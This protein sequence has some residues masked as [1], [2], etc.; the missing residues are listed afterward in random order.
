MGYTEQEAKNFIQYIAPMIRA[1]ATKRGYAICST[2][3]AQ[4]I[5]EGAAGTSLLAKAFFNHFGMK[6][7]NTWKGKTVRL[8][9][10]EEYKRGILTDVYAVFRAYDS[11]EEGVKGYYD[12]ISIKRYANLKNAKDYR[13]Y[14]E[15][16]KKDGWA[17]SSSYVENLIS[18]VEKYSLQKYDNIEAVIPTYTKGKTYKTNVNLNIRVAPEGDRKLFEDITENAK[19]HSFANEDGFAVLKKDSKVTCRDIIKDGDNLWMEIPSGYVAAYY[20]KKIYI[21]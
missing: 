9:T 7:G 1:E 3:I 6:A 17:T 16:I 12:F 10:K 8:K 18:K 20:N 21:Q 19:A 2:A 14:A 4:A 11:D 5:V 15:Y 13:Q